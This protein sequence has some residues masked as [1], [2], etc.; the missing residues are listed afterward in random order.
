METVVDVMRRLA[1]EGYHGQVRAEAS[2]LRFIEDNEVVDA[3]GVTIDEV[4]RIEGTSSPDEETAVLA[5]RREHD[6]Y[7]ATYC[8]TYGPHMDPLDV[9]FLQ[10][11]NFH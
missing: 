8:V 2:G 5:V 3:D 11:L 6:G 9:D 10:R 7:K 4:V 1:S